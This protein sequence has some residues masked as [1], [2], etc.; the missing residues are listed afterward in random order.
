M[1]SITHDQWWAEQNWWFARSLS[2]NSARRVF[3]ITHGNP[4]GMMTELAYRA[5]SWVGWRDLSEQKQTKNLHNQ[6]H[7]GR[8]LEVLVC[9]W[10]IQW[11][12]PGFHFLPPKELDLNYKTDLVSRMPY[13][14]RSKTGQ[15]VRTF[16]IASQ[17]T[18]ME[19][20]ENI[21]GTHRDVNMKRAKYRDKLAQV[22]EMNKYM[23]IPL[24]RKELKEKFW[25]LTLPDIMAFIAVNWELRKTLWNTSNH[26]YVKFTEWSEKDHPVSGLTWEFKQRI[27]LILGQVTSFISGT[28]AYIFS[29]SFL[30]Q[31]WI[32][33]NKSFHRII[34]EWKIVYDFDKNTGELNC[35]LYSDDRSELLVKVTYLFIG[36]DL[37]KL[38]SKKR[39]M[40]RILSKQ[41]Q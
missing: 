17:L 7:G 23:H 35:F 4:P 32:S 34:E 31:E 28:Q 8:A 5:H 30:W 18:L 3:G 33:R 1:N 21:I 16:S 19:L 29:D 15:K 9:E 6:L 24:S 27:R 36:N 25:K 39:N 26:A 14:G 38:S 2:T 20:P 40:N 11:K 10:L 22:R 41:Q 13:I 37:A 12:F